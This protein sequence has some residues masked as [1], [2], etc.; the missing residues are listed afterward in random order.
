MIKF[1]IGLNKNNKVESTSTEDLF[2]SDK[3]KVATQFTGTDFLQLTRF[4][5]A[6]DCAS[7]FY[8]KL[9]NNAGT[10]SMNQREKK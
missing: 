2:F 8:L 3:Q 1:N 10:S 4:F 9:I 5:S 6:P 7:Y